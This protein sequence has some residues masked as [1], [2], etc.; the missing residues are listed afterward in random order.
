[1]LCRIETAEW[2][3]QF[4]MESSSSAQKEAE[5]RRTSAEALMQFTE[6]ES[7]EKWR[8]TAEIT[9]LRSDL[10][11]ERM[12]VA[13]ELDEA[14]A[15]SNRMVS[16][17]SAEAAQMR[18]AL[19]KRA[20]LAEESASRFRLDTRRRTAELETAEATIT[21]L[22]SELAI[23]IQAIQTS[24]E[25]AADMATMIDT[26]QKQ[27]SSLELKILRHET[28]WENERIS[29]AKQLEDAS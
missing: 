7:K 22:Q 2:K 13:N 1:M 17:N 11:G 3:S 19:E 15:K 12:R 5:L 24:K 23:S 9:R 27:Q 28:C 29:L 8:L 6:S 21:Q 10:E 20:C 4:E 18:L 25:I 14:V 26:M 16:E